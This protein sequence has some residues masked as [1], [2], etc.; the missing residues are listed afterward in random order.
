[1]I[2]RENYDELKSGYKALGNNSDNG[3]RASNEKSE[4]S[5]ES[6]SSTSTFSSSDSITSSQGTSL[7]TV[8]VKLNPDEKDSKRSSLSND[9]EESQMISRERQLKKMLREKE[10]EIQQYKLR[11]ERLQQIVRCMQQQQQETLPIRGH[12][13]VRA[14]NM[15]AEN[16]STFNPSLQRGREEKP[17]Q[18]FEM[19]PHRPQ[20][21]QEIPSLT[22]EREK[23]QQRRSQDMA[24]L[25]QRQTQGR[26]RMSHSNS[27]VTMKNVDHSL[28][29][30]HVSRSPYLSTDN[31]DGTHLSRPLTLSADSLLSPS[32][33][34]T[35][36]PRAIM[37]DLISETDRSSAQIIIRH[38]PATYLQPGT[39][40]S[41]RSNRQP[42]TRF[43][44]SG[45][46]VYLGSNRRNS[47]QQLEPIIAPSWD[48]G[49]GNTAFS[50][51]TNRSNETT[52]ISDYVRIPDQHSQNIPNQ[53]SQNKP[54]QHSHN[55][56]KQASHNNPDQD[57]SHKANKQSDLMP[58]FRI[59]L[60]II[61]IIFLVVIIVSTILTLNDT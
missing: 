33:C 1:M 28:P 37:E 52:P 57:L 14:T 40:E 20:S 25:I 41:Q 29:V 24:R 43:S 61:V 7:T 32:S 45:S 51:S 18:Q 35:Q 11:Q 49:I 13:P 54:N 23:Q 19:Q 9:R 58:C 59:F 39:P 5:S 30:H 12:S 47:M 10:Q 48:S 2:S 31:T 27:Y 8:R 21:Y 46:K 36:P 38:L 15:E 6:D 4:Y 53:H 55:I 42:V 3:H 26:I 16:C 60:M 22:R 50:G 44:W 17:M 34:E 56:P